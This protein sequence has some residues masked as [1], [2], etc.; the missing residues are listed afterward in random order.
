[1]MKN[2]LWILFLSSYLIACRQTSVKEN[3]PW[4][5]YRG[6]ETSNAYSPLN[7]INTS[8]VKQLQVA[9]I[10]RTGDPSDYF[11]LECNPIIVGKMLYGISP[12]QKTFALHAAT[13]KPVWVFDPFEKNGKGGGPGR[14]LNYWSSGDEARVFMFV[15]NWMIALDARTGKQIMSFGKDGYVDLNQDLRSN[16][17]F[18]H[19]EDVGNTSP[20]VIYKDLI[21][22]GSSVSED[23]DGSP[24]HIRAYDVRTGKIK[25]IFHTVPEPGEPG[26]DTWSKES[27]QTTGGCNDW[28]G[29]SLDKKR[30]VVFVA[31]G[32]P[33][34]DFYG[35]E[36][37]GKNWFANSVIAL[38]A[39]TGKYIWHFQ[40]THHD[41]WDYDLPA[42]PNLV[43]V[44]IKD[45][46]VDAVAQVTK[47]GLVFLL[48]RET[49]T[50]LFKVEERTVPLSTVPGE[51]SWPTQPFPV[52]P[53][54]L[55]RQ[56]FNED[57]I[58]DI[59]PEA[60]A[61]ILKETK[62]YTWGDIYLPP[63]VR[64]TI[65]FPGFRGG[66]EWSGAAVDPETGILYVGINDIPNIVQLKEKKE[67]KPEVLSNLKMGEAGSILFQQNCAV[68]H[69]GDRKGNGSFPPLLDISARMRPSDV[70]GI[71]EN[72]R[73]MMPSF[74]RLS[75]ID[76][77]AIVDFLF[78][79]KSE[80]T[81]KQDSSYRAATKKP[82]PL[83]YALKGYIQ[84]LDEQG[85][86][87][88]KPPWGTLNAVNL[89]TGELVWKRPLGVFPALAKKGLPS[90]G[91][92]L[93]G[94]GAV[95]A[96]GL[97]FIGAS[98]DEKFRAI[99]K[100]TGETLWEYQLPAGGYATPAVYEID[101][102]QYIVIAAGGGGRQKTKPGD[103]YIAFAL[104]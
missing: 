18:P 93:L 21:I 88:V 66:A 71:L 91:T 3:R 77:N 7:Q 49:G 37:I 87:G 85:Y 99:D 25:W 22:I 63:S 27:Y 62:K 23:Y 56:T 57:S 42:P 86:P 48:D 2:I 80:E 12:G 36:R 54:P 45:K 33:A 24:G 32:A 31:T 1:M 83:R 101:G 53:V 79:L 68:C 104:P 84:L 26:Y 94:G 51:Q 38:D 95:T 13:G 72:G 34:F 15:A 14:G 46:P 96:G 35:A 20:G 43:T 9:W 17:S 82:V 100:A 50:P 73:G 5:V 90:T 81:Y 6:S 61:Y 10:Y 8:N 103:Y 60:H 70:Q 76:K 30:G 55:C 4:P 75:N 74:H 78:V 89:N 65:Q 28:S 39:A 44:K 64:G 67:N 98:Q 52:K 47:Q 59:S 11:N 102:K 41:L 58:T 29:L 19:R 69:G 16:A 97:I 40:T 92:Q